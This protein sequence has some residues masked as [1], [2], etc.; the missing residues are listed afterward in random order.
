VP[1]DNNLKKEIERVSFGPWP[2]TRQKRVLML[3]VAYWFG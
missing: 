1:V 2:Q 3:K